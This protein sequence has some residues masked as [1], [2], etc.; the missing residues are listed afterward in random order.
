M[1]A[2]QSSGIPETLPTDQPT[3]HP[4]AQ[5]KQPTVKDFGFTILY[6]GSGRDG[7]DALVE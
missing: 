1:D 2:G 7:E 6:D 4:P 3:D 5:I